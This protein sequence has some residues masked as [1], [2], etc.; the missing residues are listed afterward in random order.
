LD[1]TTAEE[2]ILIESLPEY[3]I[4]IAAGEGHTAAVGSKGDMYVF[5]DGKHRKLS[6]KTDSDLFEPCSI[7]KF[8]E[9]NVLKVVCGGC[10]TIILAEKSQILEP[11]Y[12]L[13]D[14]NYSKNE[15][16]DN[17]VDLSESM[18]S[19]IFQTTHIGI[20]GELRPIH[21]PIKSTSFRI[22]SKD[23]ESLKTKSKNPSKQ[24][25]N[26]NNSQ[27][28]PPTST[29]SGC[30]SSSISSAPSENELIDSKPV[31]D[32]QNNS[33]SIT[34]ETLTK[35]DTL[36]SNTDST[37][38]RITTESQPGFSKQNLPK[39]YQKIQIKI[40]EHVL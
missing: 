21:P 1:V 3:I 37:N 14:T 23:S 22:N 2:F 39:T 33:S 36:I 10:Q 31:V 19:A 24:N 40:L 27:Q 11:F 6:Y 38:S 15:P 29:T 30:T 20:N 5:G 7:D 25:V 18:T 16:N 4:D 34:H 26:D 28:S 17:K 9:Y 13:N 8:K 35:R 12:S 32:L